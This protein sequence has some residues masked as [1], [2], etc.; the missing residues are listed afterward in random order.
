MPPA[1][2]CLKAL[3]N[4]FITADAEELRVGSHGQRRIHRRR[5]VNSTA[6]TP[7][8]RLP[9]AAISSRNGLTLQSL[10]LRWCPAV[11]RT[12]DRVRSTRVSQAH[13]AAAQT[14]PVLPLMATVPRF[15]A[16][17]ARSAVLR[18]SR[19]VTPLSETLDFLVGPILRGDAG[20]LGHG[21]RDRRVEAAIQVW[22][23][24]AVIGTCCSTATSV[25]AWQMS[26]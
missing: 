21:F 1:G 12:S 4:R 23:S 20:V 25:I 22:N 11:I 7:Q 16:W 24:S 5:R 6:G 19:F 8:C 26:P 13:Q 14:A 2:V 10:A 17:N 9:V 18:I 15:S 3:F